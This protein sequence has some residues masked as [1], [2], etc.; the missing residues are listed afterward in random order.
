VTPL[1][2]FAGLASRQKYDVNKDTYNDEVLCLWLMKAWKNDPDILFDLYICS[3]KSKA[4]RTFRHVCYISCP[5][6]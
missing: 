2:K 3:N 4:L 6:W 1:E 5:Q